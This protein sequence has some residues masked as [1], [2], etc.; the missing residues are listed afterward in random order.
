[1]GR[2]HGAGEAS[3]RN[4][5]GVDG[6]E[7]ATLA[8]LARDFEARQ[9]ALR[10]S[11][12]NGGA[13]RA[14]ATLPAR[15]VPVPGAD[16]EPMPERLTTEQVVALWASR[17]GFPPDA[18]SCERQADAAR[19]L[20]GQEPEHVVRAMYG[21][22]CVWPHAPP[23]K[24]KGEPWTCADVRKKWDTA[25]QASEN[26]PDLVDARTARRITERMGTR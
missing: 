26:H 7:A 21:I 5:A 25:L 14:V 13:Q 4:P 17:Q 22:A 9:A 15:L 1:M 10:A 19:W 20:A 18:A 24:G 11:K 12:G 2:A 23:P 3:A 6:D 8:A 16:G